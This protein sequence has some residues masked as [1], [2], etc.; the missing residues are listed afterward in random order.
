MSNITELSSKAATLKGLLEQKSQPEFI[1]RCFNEAVLPGNE[2]VFQFLEKIMREMIDEEVSTALDK[3][4]KMREN[5]PVL[6]SVHKPLTQSATLPVSS[7]DIARV[8]SKFN[9]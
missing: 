1:K 3:Q 4:R 7:E 6:S 2:A 9:F 5:H 8:A